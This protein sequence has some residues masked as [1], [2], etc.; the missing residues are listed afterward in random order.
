MRRVCFLCAVVFYACTWI[1]ALN[2][3]GGDGGEY[4]A[5]VDE[6]GIPLA[7]PGG[8]ST[9]NCDESGNPQIC[10]EGACTPVD[11]ASASEDGKW[12]V[13]TKIGDIVIDGV[14][15]CG[16]S[17]HISESVVETDTDIGN[18]SSAGQ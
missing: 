1:V 18:V 14:V 16:A 5:P 9:I 7:N 6:N 3:C 11:E 8:E 4:Q 15:Q 10:K 12:L 17:I 13:K 2:A